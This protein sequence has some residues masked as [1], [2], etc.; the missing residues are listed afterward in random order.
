M[1]RNRSLHTV[2]LKL[3][4][5]SDAVT[6]RARHTP[7]VVGL[8]HLRLAENVPPR[9]TQSHQGGDEEGCMVPLF[10]DAIRVELGIDRLVFF[11]LLSSK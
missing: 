7:P 5:V 10:Y 4:R 3:Q 6:Q 11:Q 8:K 1:V 9:I 2:I